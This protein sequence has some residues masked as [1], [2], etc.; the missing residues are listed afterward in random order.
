MTSEQRSASGDKER[1]REHVQSPW[2][3]QMLDLSQAEQGD[4]RLIQNEQECMA[5][6]EDRGVAGNQSPWAAVA[7]RSWQMQGSFQRL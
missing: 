5:G 4:H 7:G 6:D 3:R 1:S 2:G